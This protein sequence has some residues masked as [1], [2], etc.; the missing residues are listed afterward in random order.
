MIADCF[1]D[2]NIL[3]YAASRRGVEEAKRIRAIELI[4]STR[5]AVSA[6]VLQEFY[7]TV[8]RKGA[9]PLSPSEALEWIEQLE[10]QPC[11]PVGAGLVKI[12][13]VLSERFRITYWDAAIIAA[14]EAM[15][16][17]TVY[18]EDLNHDQVYG[19]VRVVNPFRSSHNPSGFHEH[20]QLPYNAQ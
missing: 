18:S 7:W 4:G 1:F 6:Q 3:V 14:A 20:D 5:F 16:V 17:D 15:G 9:R 2:T 11:L 8:T 13:A 12:A 19:E 10:Q